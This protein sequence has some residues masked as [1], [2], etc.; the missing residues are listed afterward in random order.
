MNKNQKAHRDSVTYMQA[1]H[2]DEIYREQLRH[3]RMSGKQA[4]LTSFVSLDHAPTSSRKLQTRSDLFD[5]SVKHSRII[6]CCLSTG[7]GGRTGKRS[8]TAAREQGR[9][10]FRMCGGEG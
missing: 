2:R 3:P 1:G 9:R 10:E 5:I 8:K 6:A 4:K 7:C